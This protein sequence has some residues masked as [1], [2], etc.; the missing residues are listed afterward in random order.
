MKLISMICGIAAA[1]ACLATSAGAVETFYVTLKKAPDAPA[2]LKDS[3][4]HVG[5]G[6]CLPIESTDLGSDA[7]I[8]RTDCDD[9]TF[10]FKAIGEVL[11]VPG[12]DHVVAIG[13]RGG[14]GP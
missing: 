7:L 6:N 14:D 10:F 9:Q 2:A 13:F 5:T 1:L 11:A 3:I 4:L 12:V 8:Y